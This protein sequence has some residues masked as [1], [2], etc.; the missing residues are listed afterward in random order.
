MVRVVV[1]IKEMAFPLPGA[2][3]TVTDSGKIGTILQ[4]FEVRFRKRIVIRLG[5]VMLL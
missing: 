4:R 2:G 5:I 1:P 3:S